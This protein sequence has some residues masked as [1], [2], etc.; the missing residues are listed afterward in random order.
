[1]S[2]EER[3]QLARDS[4]GARKRSARNR[5]RTP[6][7]TR[8]FDRRRAKE[9]LAIIRPAW[10]LLVGCAS[11]ELVACVPEDSPRPSPEDELVV[12]VETENWDA[13]R[14]RVYCDIDELG[15]I[16][17]LAIGKSSTTKVRLGSCQNV[18]VV[19]E[20][21]NGEVWQSDP[22]EVANADSLLVHLMVDPPQSW[23]TINGTRER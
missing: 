21:I 9:L 8:V 6:H 13:T 4:V 20:G 19:A 12:T 23:F 17:D 5:W 15:V 22:I 18:V 10:R 3:R 2:D 16:R 7:A 11:V 1:M 14:L